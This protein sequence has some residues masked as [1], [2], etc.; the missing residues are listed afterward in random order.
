MKFLTYR[1]TL[2]GTPGNYFV[3]KNPRPIKYGALATD[4]AVGVAILA[5]FAGVC[6]ILIRRRRN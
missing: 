5:L 1:D 3:V 4:A 6:E 2:D